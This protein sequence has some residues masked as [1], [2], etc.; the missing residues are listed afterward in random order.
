[1]RDL[2]SELEGLQDVKKNQPHP[3]N[4]VVVKKSGA[5]VYAKPAEGARLLFNAS[6]E[7]EFEFIDGESEWI[8]VQISGLS[9]GY[10]SR[11]NLELSEYITA[12][13]SSVAASEKP[14]AFRIV[15][16]ESSPFP[17]DWAP[18][19]GKTVKIFTVQPTSQDPKEIGAQARLAFASSLFQKFV[20]ENSPAAPQLEGVVVIFDSADG[21]ILGT[22]LSTLQQFTSGA[23]SLESFWKQCY[24]DPLDAF[25]EPRKP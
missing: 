7:Y 22:T 5:S 20:P 2:N 6:A 16:E 9:R 4:L 10:I 23:L 18:L 17:G 15:R 25:E 8:H 11:N 3:V 1:M 19:K 12:R 24:R 14:A 21:G 13:L